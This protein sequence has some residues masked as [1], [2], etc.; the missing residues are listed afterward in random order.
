[1]KTSGIQQRRIWTNNELIRLIIPLMI[2][3][4]LIA[5]I[6][7]GDT[8][9]V[10]GLGEFAVGGVSLVNSVNVLF[11]D[12]FIA[13]AM[14]GTVVVS[15][16]LGRKDYENSSQ[17]AKQ[18]IYIV[19]LI[20]IGLMVFLLLFQKDILRLIFGHIEDDVMQAAMTYFRI[21]VLGY[22]FYALYCVGSA[23][24]RS[25]GNSS[26]GMGI[27][28]AGNIFDLVGNYVLIYVFSW[29][30]SGAAWST[31][32]THVLS[33]VI[34]LT[35]LYCKKIKGVEL[36]GIRHI[37][38]KRGLIRSILQVAVP[39]G[40]ENSMFQFGKIALARL[41]STFGT[42]ALAGHALA[43]HVITLGNLPGWS[44][45]MSLLTIVGQCVGAGDYEG[46][47]YYT[48]KLIKL[49][50][51]CMCVYN[52]ILFLMLPTLFSFFDISA[53]SRSVAELCGRIFCVAAIFI[54]TFSYGLPFALRAAGDGKY[55]MVA[56]ATSMWVARVGIAYLLAYVFDVGVVCVWI[57]MVCEW[58]M[59]TGFFV[60]RWRSGRWRQK[61]VLE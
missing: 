55:T 58:V 35:L 38:F 61:R 12:I 8:L 4:L 19:A 5:V 15:Q 59:R 52:I 57:S 44:I 18:V 26:I 14:G 3:R 24:F 37:R 20:A 28:F 2:E 60:S 16:Y 40:V 30:V 21:T 46:A 41:A 47:N 9:M 42:I 54:W 43:N 10:S 11:V 34:V 31:F 1:M 29:G 50:C 6:G 32:I 36:K 17:T 39:N 33:A 56:S 23:L 48:K 7:M 45:G 22:P 49:S 53:E 51:V 13:L 25:T 27:T